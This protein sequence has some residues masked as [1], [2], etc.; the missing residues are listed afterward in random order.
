[1]SDPDKMTGPAL[2][3]VE[4][5]TAGRIAEIEARRSA[6]RDAT[7]KARAEQYEKDLEALDALEAEHGEDRISA[8]KMPS[9]VHGLPTIVVVRTP[10]PSVFGRF[11]SMVRKAKGD[12][13]ALGTAKD[14]LASSCLLYP[15]DAETYAKMKDSWPSTHDVVGVEVIRLG[16][17][18]GK[19]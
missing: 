2:R 12:A 11:R 8:L 1:M 4:D 14:L 6:R 5:T 15:A 18:G 7:A 10:S 19:D 16:E 13:E 3:V 17:A 9:F